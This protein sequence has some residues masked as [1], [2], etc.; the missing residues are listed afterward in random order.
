[1]GDEPARVRAGTRVAYL[2]AAALVARVEAL[3]TVGGFDT[4][5]RFGEDVDL[6]WRL[7][8]AGWRVRFEPAARV[9]HSSRASWVE[10]FH[11][12]VGYGSSA[13]P[14]ARRHPRKLAPLRMSAWSLLAW[15]VTAAGRPVAGA[16]VGVGSALALVPKLPDVPARESF[17]LAAMGNLHAGEL[18]AN[19]IR[20]AW[21]PI[22]TIAAVRSTAAR[23]VLIASALAAR[24]PRQ[25]ADDVAYS[26]GVWRGMIAARTLEP[27]VPEVTSWPGRAATRLVTGY[28][29]PS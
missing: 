11:Q 22:L 17:R 26:L 9:L 7:D 3:R 4:S 16:L 27:I 2:P 29:R 1:M 15:F 18:I 21:W 6:V 10:L 5:L 25:L 12:R 24:D 8:D 28:G 23:R 13:G 14:L 19:T 20:R